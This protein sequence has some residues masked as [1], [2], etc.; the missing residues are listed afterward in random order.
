[1]ASRK[2]PTATEK[3]A[4]GV[5]RRSTCPLS[6]G[7]IIATAAGIRTKATMAMGASVRMKGIRRPKRVQVRSDHTPIMGRRKKAAMLSSVMITPVKPAP[8]PNPTSPGA[9]NVGLPACR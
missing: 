9:S 6:S 5:P 4:S 8:R 2:T 7:G 3:R 1:M